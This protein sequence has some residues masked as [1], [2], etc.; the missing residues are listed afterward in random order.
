MATTAAGCAAA[1]VTVP[2]IPEAAASVH[3][4]QERIARAAET[5]SLDR[6]E[7]ERWLA[8]YRQFCVADDSHRDAYNALD[9]ACR[10]ARKSHPNRNDCIRA[11]ALVPS[12][13]ETDAPAIRCIAW[14]Q[15]EI[16]RED[17]EKWY[18][19]EIAR[20]KA[21]T[22]RK[23][24]KQ[25]EE[26]R[27]KSLEQFGKWETAC[28]VV[29][30][31]FQIAELSDVERRAIERRRAA[32]AILVDTPATS[33]AG[34]AVKLAVW[35]KNVAIQCDMSDPWPRE[36]TNPELISAWKD[37]LALAGLPEGLGLEDHRKW[38]IEASPDQRAA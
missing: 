30:A 10:K 36:Q 24:L 2:V 7:A 21:W 1:A 11:Y 35:A 32:M 14:R 33:T 8:L 9:E 31:C 34:V 29:D 22:D 25:I 12:D 38:L 6:V 28:E 23:L 4:L 5:L 15:D 26:N 16:E 13:D 18:D 3:G 20:H 37:A 17:I 27:A 19:Q